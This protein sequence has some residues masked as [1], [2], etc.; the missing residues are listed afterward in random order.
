[1]ENQ[2]NEQ[3][4]HTWNAKKVITTVL[5]L[6]LVGIGISGIIKENLRDSEDLSDLESGVAST[7]DEMNRLKNR[8]YDFIAA[9]DY[10]Q[11]LEAFKE[12][13]ALTSAGSFDEHF[14]SGEIAVLEQDPDSALASFTRAYEL[15][16]EDS[17]INNTLALFY[18]DLDQVAAQYRDYE[19][20][21][22]HAKKAYEGQPDDPEIAKQNLAL[23]YYFTGDLDQA[24][25][26]LSTSDFVAY[27]ASAYWLGFVYLGKEDGDNARLYFKKAIDAG[28]DVPQ[29]IYDF[30]YSQ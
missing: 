14:I 11:A 27:P 4:P 17:Q 12:A 19:K 6:L 24:I 30:V 8:A 21:L 20:A 15:N 29:Y 25:T 1:M 9:E 26:L 18:L 23:A 28:V 13:L 10:V 22:F 16:P 7:D 2:Q 3:Q 5:I